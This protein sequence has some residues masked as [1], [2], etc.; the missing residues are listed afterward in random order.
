[1]NSFREYF[2]SFISEPTLRLLSC[3]L[4]ARASPVLTSKAHDPTPSNEAFSSLTNFTNPLLR[5]LPPQSY[6]DFPVQV[7]VIFWPRSRYFPCFST[8]LCWNFPG[9][10]TFPSIPRVPISS[11]IS[12]I[13]SANEPRQRP[14]VDFEFN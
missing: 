5:P 13:A 12:K 14:R 7:R 1:M 8:F 9:V 2:A 11:R 4:Q 3:V 6:T 10:S